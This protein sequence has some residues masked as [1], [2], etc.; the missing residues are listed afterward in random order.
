M[1]S[2]CNGRTKSG[3]VAGSGVFLRPPSVRDREEL[4]A[5]NRASRNLH[6]G[7]VSPPTEPEQYRAFLKK[8]RGADC[9]SFLICRVGDGAI[10]GSIT[11]SQIVRGNFQ[12]P[13]LGYYVGERYAG[14]GHM[15]GALGLMLRHAFFD[16]RLHRVEAN[17]RLGNV[18]S[19][20]L[21]RRAGFVREGYSR[22]Y[23][24]ICGRWRDHERWACVA[25][26]WKAKRDK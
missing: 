25:E 16:L 22:R 20:A 23:L 1:D 5:L 2:R 3:V 12:S 11:L 10:V 21:V 4:I 14:R 19:I 8:C 24:K 15:T 7:L 26:E 18:A 17:I 9:V 13:Y 6:R